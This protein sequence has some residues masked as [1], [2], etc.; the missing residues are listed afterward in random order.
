MS[1]PGEGVEHEDQVADDL[2]QPG[3]GGGEA[4]L[5]HIRLDHQEHA[6]LLRR[7][8][9]AGVAAGV[10]LRA[11]GQHALGPCG[12]APGHAIRAD[13]R[14]R[15]G[16]D[17][18]LQHV[19]IRVL[20]G[21]AIPVFAVLT[22]PAE[23]SVMARRSELR[24]M[25]RL[26]FSTTRAWNAGECRRPGRC[27]DRRPRPCPRGCR[28]PRLSVRAWIFGAGV[29]HGRELCADGAEIIVSAFGEELLDVGPR[30][31]SEPARHGDAGSEELEGL[32]DV[33]RV[34]PAERRNWSA[35]R[36]SIAG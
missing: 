1:W 4:L 11:V 8:P 29:F 24:R 3:A 23:S 7:Q 34:P 22:A 30:L 2:R 18:L 16:G 17:E 28:S 14:L 20:A 27:W 26:S 33:I 13:A 21:G 10:V 35:A 19:V 36:R 9:G 15:G 6:H 12:V 32:L 5:G 25:R 31:I